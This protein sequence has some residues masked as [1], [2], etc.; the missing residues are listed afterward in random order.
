MEDSYL[1]Y[2]EKLYLVIGYSNITKMKLGS[3]CEHSSRLLFTSLVTIRKEEAA[4]EEKSV[5]Y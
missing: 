4:K 1:N 5:T 2:T 3:A